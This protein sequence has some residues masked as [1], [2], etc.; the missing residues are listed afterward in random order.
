[1]PKLTHELRVRFDEEAYEW[2]RHRAFLDRTALAE[3]IRRCVEYAA[4]NRYQRYSND[5]SY[6]ST[7]SYEENEALIRIGEQAQ[8]RARHWTPDAILTREG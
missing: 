4:N 3:A 8:E 2:L 6:V 5:P 7:G 1:M